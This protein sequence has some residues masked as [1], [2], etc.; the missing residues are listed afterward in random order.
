MDFGKKSR[1][2]IFWLLLEQGVFLEAV[3]GALAKIGSSLKSNNQINLSISEYVPDTHGRS[4]IR[5]FN[6]NYNSNN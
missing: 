6:A 1:T 5:W 2:I 4:M 3:A